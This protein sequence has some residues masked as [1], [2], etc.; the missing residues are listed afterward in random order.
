MPMPV[1]LLLVFLLAPVKDNGQFRKTCKSG[2]QVLYTQVRF[3]EKHGKGLS[4]SEPD[5]TNFSIA[6]IANEFTDN[7]NPDYKL[8]LLSAER[9]IKDD[10]Q[11]KQVL[12]Y[13]QTQ[14]NTRRPP[15]AQCAACAYKAIGDCYMALKNYAQA[16]NFYLKS[17]K[18]L[19]IKSV[20]ALEYIQVNKPA[21]KE[22]GKRQQ[23]VG[24]NHYLNLMLTSP[25]GIPD[26]RIAGLVNLYLF[27]ADSGR[28]DYLAAFEHYHNYQRITDSL[29]NDSKGQRMKMLERRFRDS[30][31]TIRENV[32]FPA[33]SK[34][35]EEE[36]FSPREIAAAMAILVCSGCL[37]YYFRHYGKRRLKQVNRQRQHKA[38]Q[39]LLDDKAQL[40]QEKEIL[41][42]EVHHRVKNNMQ[43]VMSLLN[44]QLSY[45]N[46]EAAIMAIQENLNRL[47]AI[48]IMHQ[49]LYGEE[50]VDAVDMQTYVT[51]FIA[52]LQETLQITENNVTINPTIACLTLDV[53]RA[54]LVGLLIGEGISSVLNN[55]VSANDG[56]DINISINR[57]VENQIELVIAYPNISAEV[58][59]SCSLIN[60]RLMK[61]LCEQLNGTFIAEHEPGL[62]LSIKFPLAVEPN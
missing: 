20:S 57:I 16:K 61:I 29:F 55:A 3:D 30:T 48:V 31:K 2:N 51:D 35:L 50:E 5:E 4:P 19:P 39:R 23:Q 46:N 43:M 62:T 24:I 33:P 37:I 12:S 17:I 42:I 9:L 6:P 59:E 25:K 15:D 10:G 40:I 26:P 58:R 44:T 8:L 28:G 47:Q 53:T 52:Y 27:K 36:L 32:I 21:W 56:G 60:I 14:V 18:E 54:T 34:N 41:L 1:F 11:A 49:N 45:L 22:G 13:L 7:L 38:L